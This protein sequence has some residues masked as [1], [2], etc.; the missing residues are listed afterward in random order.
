[1]R[2]YLV[3]RCIFYRSN[4]VHNTFSQSL[5]YLNQ[6]RVNFVFLLKTYLERWP[7]RCLAVIS[8]SFF[9]ICSWC[10]HACKFDSTNN[11]RISMFDAMWLFIVTFTTIGKTIQFHTFTYI[12]IS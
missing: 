4:L 11:R 10:L 2:I 1:M 3:C 12:C 5:G 6:V 8:I 9:L 7:T